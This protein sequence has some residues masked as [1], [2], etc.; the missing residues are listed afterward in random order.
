SPTAPTQVI[1][2]IPKT[3]PSGGPKIDQML[4][5][6]KEMGASDLHLSCAMPPLV[7]KDGEMKPIPGFPVNTPESMLALLYEI[8]PE[9]NRAEYETRNDTDFAYEIQGLSRFR[10]N[11]FRDRRGPGG[12]FRA[13][14]FDI[15]NPSQLGLPQK[16]LELCYLTKGL[17]LVTGPTG[18][19]KSTT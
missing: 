17:V 12:V 9:K 3:A 7:R 6:M 16:V 2:T 10:A 11:M 14:P 1:P 4:R 8:C 15:L 13:I 19:G 18:S 5:A